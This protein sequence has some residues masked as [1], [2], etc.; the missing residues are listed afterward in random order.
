MSLYQTLQS[1]CRRAAEKGEAGFLVGKLE[2]LPPKIRIYIYDGLVLQ[3]PSLLLSQNIKKELAEE[4]LK[5]GM[6]V[7]L[8]QAGGVY[9]VMEKWEN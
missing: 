9:L 6:Q 2:S 8:L 3:A 7:L 5:A 4:T 1:I